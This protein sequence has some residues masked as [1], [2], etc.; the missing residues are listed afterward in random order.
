MQL[1]NGILIPIIRIHLSPLEFT[2][3]LIT[4]SLRITWIQLCVKDIISKTALTIVH[5]PR[6]A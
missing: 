1:G 4:S 2:Q 5:L 6:G 3:T